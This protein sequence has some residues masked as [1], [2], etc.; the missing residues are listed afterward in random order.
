MAVSYMKYIYMSRTQ[1]IGQLEYEG[2]SNEVAEKVVAVYEAQNSVDW[3]EIAIL[4]AED[5]ISDVPM[6]R[7]GL[8]S[9]MTSDI[10]NFSSKQAEVAVSYLEDNNLVDWNEQAVL[11]GE[12]MLSY[13]EYERQD[14][15]QDMTSEWGKQFTREQAEYAADELGIK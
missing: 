12:E 10:I 7:G 11:V 13:R 6:S 9:I 3:E 5:F 15:I 14:F 2:Y 4:W 1:L 8:I